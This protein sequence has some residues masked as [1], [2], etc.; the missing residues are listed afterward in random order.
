M[1]YL[2]AY[3][4]GLGGGGSSY[5]GV[6]LCFYFSMINSSACNMGWGG[7]GGSHGCGRPVM[8]S[9]KVLNICL[10]YRLE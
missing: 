1:I 4:M 6:D 3:M 2:S 7:G 8:L 10:Y 5:G 9:L